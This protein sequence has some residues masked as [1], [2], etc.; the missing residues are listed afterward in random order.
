MVLDSL[1]H[2]GIVTMIQPFDSA[3]RINVYADTLA[4]DG[5]YVCETKIGELLF[6]S[7]P[8]LTHVDVADVATH[9]VKRIR[10]VLKKHG[11]FDEN[12]CYVHN[13]QY[14]SDSNKLL[15]VATK[16]LL[17]AGTCFHKGHR[18]LA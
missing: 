2:P 13:E 5:V 4:L 15:S 12:N 7:L 8:T 16:H 3:F 18:K 11:R 10:K 14:L 9:T 6:H 17:R 1:A